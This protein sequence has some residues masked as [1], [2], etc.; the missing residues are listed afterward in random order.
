[1]K[2]IEFDKEQPENLQTVLVIDKLGTIYIV[3]CELHKNVYLSTCQVL[4]LV[5]TLYSTG[6]IKHNCLSCGS[7]QVTHWMPLPEPPKD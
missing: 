6:C 5:Y 7:V 2:W 1:M 4:Y 3:K